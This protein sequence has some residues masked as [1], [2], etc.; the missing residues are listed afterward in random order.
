MK[1]VEKYI[2]VG[3]V[4]ILLFL[5]VQ[6]FGATRE[7]VD[8]SAPTVPTGL[9]IENRTY[10]SLVISWNASTDNTGVRGYQV[11]RDGRKIITI[12]KT[13]FTN[14]DLVPGREY[15]Y[16]IRAYDAAGNVSDGSAALK[17]MTLTDTI[18]PLIPEQLTVASA[19]YTS[20]S[21]GWKPS[22]DNTS[23]KGYEIY[24][25][26]IRKASTSA[27]SYVC[28]GLMPGKSYEF[29]VKAYDIAGNYSDASN[30]IIARTP[31][32]N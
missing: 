6:V 20:V 16:T 10:S 5:P 23:I 11:Y 29:T 32:D 8:L 30:I 13:S 7:P 21:L 3:L 9:A 12:S 15:V 22:A 27:T 26:G 25:N 18:P 1:F 28:K 2:L 31:A 19:G 24:C 4:M 14:T 17:G